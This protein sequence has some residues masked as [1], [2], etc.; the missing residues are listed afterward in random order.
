[1]DDTGWPVNPEVS[2]HH[3]AGVI[4]RFSGSIFLDSLWMLKFEFCHR[5][6]D[7]GIFI[8]PKNPKT[9]GQQ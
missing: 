9:I 3:M 7:H 6:I 4:D 1:M 2:E 8:T 5:F